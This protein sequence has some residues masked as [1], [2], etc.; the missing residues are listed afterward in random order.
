[1]PRYWDH[2][3]LTWDDRG[4]ADAWSRVPR[5][6]RRWRRAVTQDIHS[7]PGDLAPGEQLAGYEIQERI[8]RGGMAVVY[9]ALDLRLGRLVALKV[10]APH[11]GEDEA[12][13]QRFMRESRAAAGVDHPHIVPVFEAGEAAG[14]LFI[15]MRYVSGGDVRSLIEA[16]GRLSAARTARIAG[17]VASA[18]DAAH[19]HGLVHRD[20]KPANIL[21]GQASGSDVDHVYLSDFGLSKHSLAPTT[22]TS[23]GQF[24]GTLDYVAPE[25]IQGHPVDGRADQYGLACAVVEMLSG[26][27]PFRREDSMALMWAQLE[28]AP[29]RLTERR[30]ELPPA[31]DEVI[32][33]A[34]S[35][36]PAGRYPTCR[37]FAAA[38]ATAV[39]QHVP[40]R[41]AS[42]AALAEPFLGDAYTTDP[43]QVGG[44]RDDRLADGHFPADRLAAGAF[45]A[46]ANLADHYPAGGLVAEPGF[47]QPTANP[48]SDAPRDWFRGGDPTHAP[49]RADGPARRSA[50]WEDGPVPGPV[51]TFRQPS[52]HQAW[53]AES[54]PT[55]HDGAAPPGR[56]TQPGRPKQPGRPTQPGHAQGGRRQSGQHRARNV[57]IGLLIAIVGLGGLA[58]IAY[59]L[60]HRSDR[61]RPPVTVTTTV[62]AGGASNPALTVRKYFAAI[63]HR[64]YRAAWR[65]GGATEPYP[66]FR[67]GYVG[68][69]RDTVTILSVNG[70]IV[71]ARLAALQANGT[72]KTYRGTY[73]VTN[74]VISAT[75]V[76]Q[77]N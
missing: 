25:Q 34:M 39:D 26:A 63:N 52:V 9:R 66:V 58:G 37:D 43:L 76:Q 64:Q 24:L 65:L 33:T 62:P 68:T 23:T 73:T 3:V 20:V 70:N 6:P 49:E 21:L 55:R 48:W 60:S 42:S 22:L 71:S 30:P 59:K 77:T 57:V 45:G 15:A 13:R 69:V 4:T 38:L 74:G 17:Q 72:V 16:Q 46:A 61:T 31:V 53:P 14:V 10:L 47:G 27:P 67:K 35:K 40:Q 8:G 75:N 11:L 19:A 44:L 32:A 28:A 50:D 29:P 41:T 56:P 7:G 18:L 54:P 1:M 12:F 2:P 36:A 51:G 5:K